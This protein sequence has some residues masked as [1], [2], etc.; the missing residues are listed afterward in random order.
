M[1]TH[2]LGSF[3]LAVFVVATGGAAVASAQAPEMSPQQLFEAGRYAE[4]V[5]AIPDETGDDMKYLEAQAHLRLNQNDEARSRLQQMGGG[6]ENNPWTFIGR[7]AV[8]QIEGNAPEAAAQ[9]RRAAELNGGLPEAHYQL[10]QALYAANNWA[11]AADAFAQAATLAPTHAYAHYHAG[12]AFYRA[13]RVD[14][15]AQ[16]FEYFLK[17]APQAPE[18][19][20][21][22]AV[23]RTVRGR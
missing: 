5:Q 17:L 9:A 21:V 13:K 12:Q 16:H 22:E 2:I 20:Q 11:A 14:R 15:M 4:T 7:S 6:D 8:A 18:R 10:G 3:V 23:M 19:P 1:R